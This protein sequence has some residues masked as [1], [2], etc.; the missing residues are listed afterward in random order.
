MLI[1]VAGLLAHVCPCGDLCHSL[2]NAPRPAREVFLVSQAVKPHPIGGPWPL[3]RSKPPIDWRSWDLST[4]TT[5]VYAWGH[6]FRWHGNGSVYAFNEYGDVDPFPDYD[7]LCAAHAR[8]IRVIVSVPGGSVYGNASAMLPNA[9]RHRLLAAGLVNLTRAYGFDGIE[10]DFEGQYK[11]HDA[12]VW[13]QYV[14]FLKVITAARPSALAELLAS[15]ALASSA[16][17]PRQVMGGA[18]RGALPGAY[19]TITHQCGPTDFM[20]AHAADVVEATDG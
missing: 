4:A 20:A 5:I 6:P 2:V 9:T 14:A 8:G 12:T 13:S 16:L 18:M 17:A 10:I 3:G 1:V 7:L 19:L 15:S 11:S